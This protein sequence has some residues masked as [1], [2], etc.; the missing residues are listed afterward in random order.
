MRALAAVVGAAERICGFEIVS[1]GGESVAFFF[2]LVGLLLELFILVVWVELGWQ[3]GV[4]C[5]LCSV[6][7]P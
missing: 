1:K 7:F 3:A 4:G 5:F 2:F 6:F